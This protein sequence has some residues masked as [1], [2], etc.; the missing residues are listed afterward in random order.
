M[1]AGDNKTNL[2]LRLPGVDRCCGCA[3]C[4][5]ACPVHAI[6]MQPDNEGFLQPVVDKSIC[7]G[8][9]KCEKVCPVLNPGSPRMPLA[10]YA[11]KAKDDE[12]RR[13][14]SSGGVFSLLARQVLGDGGVVYGAAFEPPSHKV[15]HKRV[16]DEAGLDELRGSKYVQSEI[17]DA[18]CKVKEDLDLGHKVLF[19]GCPCQVAGLRRFLGNEYDNLLSVDVICHAVPSPLAWQ[20][21]LSCQE[22]KKQARIARTFSRRNCAWRKYALSLEFVKSSDSAPMLKPAPDTYMRAFCSEL[23]NRRCCQ[24]CVFRSFRSGS[25]ITIGDFW[26]VE[27]AH[28]EINDDIGVSA[29]CCNTRKGQDSFVGVIEM[30][31]H[32][33]SSIDVVA[34]HNKTIFG[35]HRINRKRVAFFSEVSDT[36]FDELVEKLL[37]PPWWYRAL[38]WIK[39]HTIGKP[40]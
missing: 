21:Y 32:V 2:A 8:C 9:G 4:F 16:T 35:N 3:A 30:T 14:S 15:V 17:G 23:F 7:I 37:T 34:T 29:V 10:V 31:K 6:S 40:K 33:Q 12:L 27:I 19:S 1:N 20:K 28:P 25:D 5:A 13:I 24:N 36:N 11:A 22:H 38:R 26:G 39:W 18:F